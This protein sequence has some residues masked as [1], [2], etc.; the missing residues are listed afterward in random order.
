[1]YDAGMREVVWQRVDEPS[2]QPNPGGWTSIDVQEEIDFATLHEAVPASKSVASAEL[3]VERPGPPLVYRL[4]KSRD[5]VPMGRLVVKV[6]APLQGT[7][8]R[9]HDNSDDEPD[10]ERSPTGSDRLVPFRDPEAQQRSDAPGFSTPKHTDS[11]NV[12][13]LSTVSQQEAED[14]R[15]KTIPALSEVWRH[16]AHNLQEHFPGITPLFISRDK[17]QFA[18][19]H[20][21]GVDKLQSASVAADLRHKLLQAASV[22]RDPLRPRGSHDPVPPALTVVERQDQV[23]SMWMRILGHEDDKHKIH[24]DTRS[25]LH[26]CGHLH[27]QG[28]TTFGQQIVNGSIGYLR[29]LKSEI[30]A[31]EPARAEELMLMLPRL[32]C[33]INLHLNID[34]LEPPPPA[35]NVTGKEHLARLMWDSFE[36]LCQFYNII[37]QNGDIFKSPQEVIAGIRTTLGVDREHLGVQI[38]MDR[39]ENIARGAAWFPTTDPQVTPEGSKCTAFEKQQRRVTIKGLDALYGLWLAM[40]SAAD[41]LGVWLLL[42]GATHLLHLLGRK[43]RPIVAGPVSLSAGEVYLMGL[44]CL[45]SCGI[46]EVMQS[47]RCKS[48]AGQP[49]QTIAEALGFHLDRTDGALN[50][51]NEGRSSAADCC[52]VGKDSCSFC[53][54]N[55]ESSEDQPHS[56]EQQSGSTLSDGLPSTAIEPGAL[57]QFNNSWQLLAQLLRWVTCGVP[58]LLRQ[59]LICLVRYVKAEKLPLSKICSPRMQQLFIGR[60]ALL[61]AIALRIARAG[62]SAPLRTAIPFLAESHLAD[63]P[64]YNSKYQ[65]IPGIKPQKKSSIGNR[66]D[67]KL[68]LQEQP[69][70]LMLSE[71]ES[72]HQIEVLGSSAVGGPHPQLMGPDLFLQAGDET[73][74]CLVVWQIKF[75]SKD[76]IPISSIQCEINRTATQARGWTKCKSFL[77]VCLVYL[78][79]GQ[80]PELAEFQLGKMLH[81]PPPGSASAPA[82]SSSKLSIPNDLTVFVP[83]TEQIR[84]LLGAKEMQALSTLTQVQKEAK[85]ASIAAIAAQ[86]LSPRDP[87]QATTA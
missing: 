83:N 32:L 10:A 24:T 36:N 87:R 50:V 74:R 47:T 9:R 6:V 59:A 12:R 56:S 54:G 40:S 31:E 5:Q 27:G 51:A 68:Q 28:K 84:V 25:V 15:E 73:N 19:E 69:W 44:P 7:K 20:F 1:M 75:C 53:Q 52:L 61:G 16:S 8:R 17:L 13:G 79:I 46:K 66:T 38:H 60:E 37:V 64:V 65:D 85:Q 39:A 26:A 45:T 43:Y 67:R 70:D 3:Y 4:M 78:V 23:V 72:G 55:T 86:L 48:A 35:T 81:A 62:S 82:S 77:S 57:P 41:K 14:Y 42:T 29:H 18:L 2:A 58:F 22:W 71:T 76:P 33:S 80:Q 21:A 49:S 34:A 11:G 30:Q 63:V